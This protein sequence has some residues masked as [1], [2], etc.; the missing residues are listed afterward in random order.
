MKKYFS[1][2]RINL[3]GEHIDYNGGNVFPCAIDL[4]VSA[5][6]V[7]NSSNF[8]QFHSKGTYSDSTVKVDF[9]KPFEKQGMWTD[10]V[11]G[12]LDVLRKHG[13][14]NKVGFNL[15]LETT[16]PSGAGLSSSACI[17]VLM[18][19]ILNDLNNF[20]LT[21]EQIA[22]F[23]QEAENNFV[24]VNCGIMDQFIIANGKKDHA[25]LLN[26]DTLQFETS[27]INLGEYVIVILNSNK[28]RGLVESA[29]NER[30]EQCATATNIISQN[31]GVKNACDIS[32]AQLEKIKDQFDSVVY[33]RA[34]HIVSEQERV[35]DAIVALSKND[36]KQFANLITK[37]HYSL[38]DDFAVSC[39][40]LDYIV[41]SA[42]TNGA[43][44][45]RMVGAG[46]GGCAIAIVEKDLLDTFKTNV[47]N[48]YSKEFDLECD[49][50]D[51]NIVDKCML[52]GENNE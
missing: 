8:I 50:Y 12:V 48:S 19:V 36:I 7:L 45:A 14:E 30:R 24:G 35:T 23:S 20:N 13:Y 10:Y 2:G 51:V 32:T 46:F 15:N 6:V 39:I 27:K 49:I 22:L 16:L 1:P 4:G 11:V 17:E 29:Y 47:K 37:T 41:E 31:Y 38:K 28:K 21:D 40:E 43:I 25:L 5:E 18:C 42:L 34:L 44:G 52:V 33:K 9:T 3:I 26:T